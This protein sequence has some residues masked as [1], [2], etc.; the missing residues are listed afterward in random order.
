MAGHPQPSRRRKDPRHADTDC[1]LVI[2]TYKRACREHGATQAIVADEGADPHAAEAPR[3]R[4]ERLPAGIPASGSV[5]G[6][7]WRRVRSVH[8][9]EILVVFSVRQQRAAAH[10]HIPAT[11]SAPDTE[12][13][14]HAAGPADPALPGLERYRTGPPPPTC[15]CPP[16]RTTPQT[17]GD[18]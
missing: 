2:P 12:A 3:Q 8:A 7:L 16:P 15:D 6:T 17:Q 9:I 18:A 13:H 5:Y 1:H 10:A 11:V 14:A 4:R